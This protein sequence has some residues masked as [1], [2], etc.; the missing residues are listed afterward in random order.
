VVINKIDLLP[1]VRFDLDRAVSDIKKLR[2]D[3]HIVKTS[4]TT[5]EG[6]DDFFSYLADLRR[7]V[8][9]AVEA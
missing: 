6:L 1:Y 9:G 2:H 5:G 3:V 4:C 8:H 7:T